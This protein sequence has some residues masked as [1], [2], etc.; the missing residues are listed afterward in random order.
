MTGLD[1]GGKGEYF[2]L[3]YQRSL[4]AANPASAAEGTIGVK[5]S[6][7]K[8]DPTL[9]AGEALYAAAVEQARSPVFYADFGTPDT[10]EG[11]FEQVALHVYLI[12]RR[13]KDDQPG[14]KKVG[15][16]LFDVMFQN[17]DD[18]LRELGVGDMSI[19]RKIRTL[20][21]NFYGRVAAYED[22]LSGGGDK[23]DLKRA[24]GRNIFEDEEASEAALLADYV[25]NAAAFIEAQPVPR[26]V[27]GIVRFPRAQI[28]EQQQTA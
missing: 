6:F 2:P 12:L 17:M 14:A 5:M 28:T 23:D 13:L 4:R 21:G 26:I 27:G 9:E 15:Q 11:R 18:A 22:S 7:F 3:R 20:A 19:G 8:K 10:V 16:K 1:P 25:R 24:L